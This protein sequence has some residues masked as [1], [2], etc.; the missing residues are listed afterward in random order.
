MKLIR[1]SFI[2]KL[3]F[4]LILLYLVVFLFLFVFQGIVFRTYYTTRTINNVKR[5]ISN[6][7]KKSDYEEIKIEELLFSRNTQTITAIFPK[8]NIQDNIQNLDLQIIQIQESGN[9]YN[10]LAPKLDNYEYIIGETLSST[11]IEIDDYFLPLELSI[12]ENTIIRNQVD[13]SVLNGL[14]LEFTTTVTQKITE[15]E[16]ISISDTSIDQAQI[17]ALV[18]NEIINISTEN[19]LSKVPFNDGFYYYS[20]ESGDNSPNL[21]FYSNLNINDTDYVLIS[22]YQMD[23]VNEIVK[24]A[25]T[26]NI[27]MFIVVLTILIISSFIYSREFSKPLLFINNATK[28][29]SKLNLNIPLIEVGTNDEFAQLAHN[30]NVLSVNLKTTL[31]RLNNQNQ[32]LTENLIVEN[33]NEKRRIDFVSGMSHE[34]KTPLAVIQASAEALQNNIF[35]TNKEKDMALDSIQNEVTK[36]NNMIK[37]MMNVYKIDAPN[38][39]QEWT[40]ENLD[41]ILQEVNK[42]LRLLYENSKISVTI[43]SEDTFVKC[44]KDRIE[45]IIVN[46]FNNAI[47]YTPDGNKIEINLYN[48][49]KLVVF[50]ITNFGTTIDK[51]NI[52]K[53][54]DPFYRIDKAR[55]RNEGSSGL[56]LY[57]VSESLKQYNTKCDVE[58][59]NDSVK[60][61]FK[62]KK[63]INP[64]D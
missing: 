4:S 44:N 1:S 8:S 29:L 56:G 60:F 51:A 47:K 30:I 37:S 12:E 7:K 11:L 26:T 24:A 53:L 17:N 9:I 6:L 5:E 61:S 48:Q 39:E 43:N 13:T 58:S 15:A 14:L 21:V 33:Q 35:D 20:F 63:V 34:L 31:D 25:G 22:V 57:I 42:S 59:T 45:T 41:S 19:Y 62:L 55:S 40:I 27:Y 36:T 49:K 54:F 38:Y 32:Q 46:L 50:E 64:Q 28:E 3:F 2:G 16:I 10:I 52:T 23:H 18:S